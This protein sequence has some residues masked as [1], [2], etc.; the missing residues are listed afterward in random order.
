MY[1]P[2]NLIVTDAS[3][4]TGRPVSDTWLQSLFQPTGI[5]LD[6]LCMD[7]HLE[8]ALTYGL[9]PLHLARVFGISPA[10]AMRYTTAAKQ[11]LKPADPPTVTADLR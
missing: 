2:L 8:E 11:L 9:D 7:R 6:R 10:T 4:L 1:E 5:T 3:A